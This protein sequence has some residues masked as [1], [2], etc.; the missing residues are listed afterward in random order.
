VRSDAFTVLIPRFGIEGS[1]DVEALAS[2]LSSKST[3][4][5]DLHTLVFAIG[6]KGQ[7]ALR[8]Q[9]F[10]Q[11]RVDICAVEGPGGTRKLEI[12]LADVGSVSSMESDD[13]AH[14]SGDTRKEQEV[15]SGKAASVPKRKELCVIDSEPT[16]SKKQRIERSTSKSSIKT[17]RK[18]LS[19]K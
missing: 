11:V 16:S 4:D 10:Q 19:K 15:V 12:T 9:V 1:I 6:E 2:R 8:I 13:V 5:A 18:A 7:E 17:L 3:F 14:G